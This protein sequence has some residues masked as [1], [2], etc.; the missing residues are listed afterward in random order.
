MRTPYRAMNQFIPLQEDSWLLLKNVLVEHQLAKSDLLLQPGQVCKHIFFLQTGLLR[1]FYLKEGEER[2][3]AFT[4]ENGFV[5]DLKSLRSAQPSDLSIQALEPS[6]LVSIPKNDLLQLYER[7]HQLEAFGR[8]LLENLLEEQ[9]EY[10]TWFTL[11]SAKERYTQLV[12]KQP[13]LVQRVS[14]GHL[15]SFWVFA[16][17]R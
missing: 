8:R 4:L 15:A 14:L 7:S 2:N 10:A 3:V 6:T 11:Y 9:E 1:S 17:K 16:G 13:A 12:K 5:T